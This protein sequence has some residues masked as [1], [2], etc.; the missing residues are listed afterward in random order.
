M[1]GI[2][3][4]SGSI[5]L[6]ST[7]ENT[8]FWLNQA[9][10]RCFCYLFLFFKVLKK[11]EKLRA[12]TNALLTRFRTQKNAESPLESQRAFLFIGRL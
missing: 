6:I 5:P 10:N 12:I 7:K 9:I 1:N 2:Q 11:I 8:D 4:V 3:E